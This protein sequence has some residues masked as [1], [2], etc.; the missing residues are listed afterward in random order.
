MYQRRTLHPEC[1]VNM[2]LTYCISMELLSQ[3]CVLTGRPKYFQRENVIF[4]R[5]NHCGASYIS[6]LWIR[7]DI[8]VEQNCENFFTQAFLL[9][10]QMP[11]CNELS[12]DDVTNVTIFQEC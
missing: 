7:S 6:P 10:K 8:E 5:W 3:V 2:I 9:T 1:T 4:R 12:E 11:K